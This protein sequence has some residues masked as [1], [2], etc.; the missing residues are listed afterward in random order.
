M[1]R[2]QFLDGTIRIGDLSEVTGLRIAQV[3]AGTGRAFQ[4]IAL[5]GEEIVYWSF[6]RAK[7]NRFAI[8]QAEEWK[9]PVDF[10]SNLFGKS[11]RFKYS[12]APHEYI[13]GAAFCM[14]VAS[15]LHIDMDSSNVPV[16]LLVGFGVFQLLQAYRSRAVLKTFNK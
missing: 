5:P 15:F 10:A 12:Y 4:V 2:K 14:T 9:I 16:A 13:L 7:V 6:L 8:K 3:T 1:A 11:L